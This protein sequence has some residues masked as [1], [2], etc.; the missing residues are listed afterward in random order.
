MRFKVPNKEEQNFYTF[1]K[2][3]SYKIFVLDFGLKALLTAKTSYLNAT[4]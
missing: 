4:D 1:T 3:E 2:R